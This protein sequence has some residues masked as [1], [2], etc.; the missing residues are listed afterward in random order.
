MEH[1]RKW[2]QIIYAGGNAGFS[3]LD[4]IFGVYL[5]FF[6]I[7][8][9]ET[10]MPELIHNNPLFLGITVLGFI[11]IFGRIIDSLADPLIAHWSDNATFRLGRRKFFMV[12]G[13]LPFAVCTVLLFFPPDSSASVLNAVYSA[14]VLGIYFFFY[15]YF[16]A[17][18]LAL[19]PE[20]SHSHEDR[21][22]ITV[23]QAVF[24]LLGGAVILMGVP[25]LWELFQK[26]SMPKD[27]ALKLTLIIMSVIAFVLMITSALPVNEKRYSVSKP[28]DI[29]L[30]ESLKMTITN[31]TFIIYMVPTILF[32]FAFNVI[33]ST[34]AYYPM[35]LL[36]KD[37]SYQTILMVVLFGSAAVCFV[38]IT[39]I[40]R[41]VSNKAIMLAG[42]L[43]FAVFM[44]MTYFTD[45]TGEYRVLYANINMALLGIPVAILLV[46]PNAIISDISEVD[47]HVNGINR[48]AMFFGTQGLFMKV[49]YG[50]AAAIV[51]YLFAAFGKDVASPLGVKLA[52]PVGG[53]FSLIGFFLFLS[54]PQK[55]I[56]SQLKRIREKL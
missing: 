43:T 4:N 37:Q 54:Y 47:G 20:L 33:R 51:S 23:L 11:I 40:T 50:I 27:P 22:F 28:A 18:Y 31:K 42:L 15:T 25:I 5:I 17:P 2:K 21:I 53:I 14:L 45:T 34:V 7:P 10:G 24:S 39:L 46:I 12:T 52:G 36:Q 38:F 35:V 26:N 32:W 9:R 48:E 55:A 16:M 19:I 13:S 30:L 1:F 49:N 44:F 3:I 29:G 6:L 56:S 41:W 8:P